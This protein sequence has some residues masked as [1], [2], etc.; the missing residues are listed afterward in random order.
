MCEERDGENQGGNEK[1]WYTHYNPCGEA[2]IYFQHT[3]V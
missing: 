3:N 1:V 2:Q